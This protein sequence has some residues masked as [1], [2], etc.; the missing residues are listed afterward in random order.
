MFWAYLAALTVIV[1]LMPAFAYKE[2]FLFQRQERPVE[3]TGRKVAVM[4]KHGGVW[5]DLVFLN[6]GAAYILYKYAGDW[7]PRTFIAVFLA[8]IVVGVGPVMQWAEDSKK[9]PESLARKG[10]LTI[11][12]CVHYIYM[13]LVFA[14]IAMFYFASSGVSMQATLWITAALVAHMIVGLIEPP[15]VTHHFVPKSAFLFLAIGCAVLIAFAGIQR[16]LQ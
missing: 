16:Y 5:S 11:G 6:P 7:N 1:L 14:M 8:A 10:L 3:Y 4:I 13:A 2:G 15:L 12:G 9:V